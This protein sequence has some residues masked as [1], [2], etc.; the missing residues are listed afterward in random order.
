MLTLF[1]RR[2]RRV[3]SAPI[4][5]DEG[6]EGC[7]YSGRPRRR[8]RA[9]DTSSLQVIVAASFGKKERCGDGETSPARAA[10]RRCACAARR[11]AWRVQKLRAQAARHQMAPGQVQRRK[12]AESRSEYVHGL[13]GGIFSCGSHRGAARRAGEKCARARARDMAA[14]KGA[15]PPSVRARWRD[16]LSPSVFASER[17][18]PRCHKSLVACVAGVIFLWLG[19]TQAPREEATRKFQEI[20]QAFQ[21][22]SHWKETGADPDSESEARHPRRRRCGGGRCRR[23]KARSQSLRHRLGRCL[24]STALNFVLVLGRE[25]LSERDDCGDSESEREREGDRTLSCPRF[26]F[27]FASALGSLSRRAAEPLGRNDGHR[28]FP[29]TVARGASEARAER[30]NDSS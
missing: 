1:F 21:A 20:N 24:A 7:A 12:T 9:D 30:E 28:A 10:A 18:A 19:A 14:E 27:V 13:L 23:R 3:R 2:S 15:S 29:K 25:L 22:L 17:V 5:Q 26:R 11:G 6:E 4:S 16:D 8:R